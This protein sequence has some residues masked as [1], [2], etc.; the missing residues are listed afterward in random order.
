[1]SSTLEVRADDPIR[2]DVARELIDALPYTGPGTL[3]GRYMRRFWQPVYRSRDLEP[4]RLTAVTIMSEQ[5][6]L[7]R[8]ET[9]EP[10]LVDHRCPHRG[11]QLSVGFVEG[12]AVRCLYHGWKFDGGGACIER[13]GEPSDGA[14]GHIRIGAFPVGEFMGL[15]WVYLGEGE[16]PAFP[17]F[18]EIEGDGVVEC[19][20]QHF[21]C[22]YFQSTEND[23]DL[24]HA[25]FTHRTGGIHNLDFRRIAEY[26]TCE[27]T[28][29][30]IVRRSIGP[31]NAPIVSVLFMP[32]ALRFF[33]P[34]NNEVARSGL[35]P[36]LRPAYGVTVPID[37]ENC[38]FYITELVKVAGEER[39]E[40]LER[41]PDVQ[42]FRDTHPTPIE[43]AR[44]ILETPASVLDFKDHAATVAIED[45]CAQGGQGRVADRRR[46]RLG[47]SDRCLVFMRRIWQRELLALRDGRPTKNWARMNAMPEGFS[48]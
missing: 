11:T 15:I 6:T 47:A 25:A 10:H 20:R 14:R 19:F 24:F 32:T 31:N 13:P 29:Y 39:A 1:M 46:E 41:F 16:P 35:G 3:A 34:G 18:P 37:D 42:A 44:R 8:G 2:A 40:Y 21:P 12:D 9:G 38:Y 23:W 28:D 33:L 22:N 7:Y 26:E 27:E 5:F 4:G 30:G 45:I 43:I 36:E 17:P 48:G